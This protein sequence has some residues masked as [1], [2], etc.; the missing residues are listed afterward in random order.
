MLLDLIESRGDKGKWFAA[1]KD[2]GYPRHRGRMRAPASADPSTL[3]RRPEISAT[4]TLGFTTAVGLLAVRH[5]LVGGGY[6]PVVSE[7]SEAVR[8]L[9]AAASRIEAADW[10][11]ARTRPTGQRPVRARA[12]AIPAGRTDGVVPAP[13]RDPAP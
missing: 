4:P 9:L 7:A 3:V 12:E 8:R 5:L 10:A 6:D 13:A 2:A 1:A 11:P